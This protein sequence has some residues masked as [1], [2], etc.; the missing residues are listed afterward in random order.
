MKNLIICTVLALIITSCT[1]ENLEDFT[2]GI[3]PITQKDLLCRS[4]RLIGN[5]MSGSI[6]SSKGNSNSVVI[7][8]RPIQVEISAGVILYI[9]YKLSN[10][11][12]ACKIYIQ[13][14]GANNYWE[15]KVIKDPSSGNPY[16]EILIPRFVL[17]G[18]FN[19]IYSVEDCSGNI[20]P[21][22]RTITDV[23]DVG[24]C[25]TVL[26][27]NVGITIRLIDFGE[28]AGTAILN[29]EAF[30]VPDRLDI[31]YKGKWIASTGQLLDNKV[32]VPECTTSNNGFVSGKRALSFQYN[33]SESRF[34]E[35][36]ISGCLSGTAWE[37][38]P[39]CPQ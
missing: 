21:I 2:Y 25:N 19:F 20:S 34:V 14:E 12:S 28:K 6:P 32:I 5:N 10:I 16:F 24:D 15:T 7:I 9:P 30:Q 11:N 35:V 33:P 3:S 26:K 8:S 37:L 1:K 13:V 39:Q 23:A 4:I 38:R 31:R 36:F 29:F 18:Q 22:Y 27:G 17:K